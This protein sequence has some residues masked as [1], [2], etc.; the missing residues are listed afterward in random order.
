MKKPKKRT[1]PVI[2]NIPAD[3]PLGIVDDFMERF[4]KAV[5]EAWGPEKKEHEP[6]KEPSPK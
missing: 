5:D 2:V 3:M 4:I 6:K 1:G